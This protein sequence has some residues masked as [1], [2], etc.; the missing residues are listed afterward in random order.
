MTF[1]FCVSVVLLAHD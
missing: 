1:V